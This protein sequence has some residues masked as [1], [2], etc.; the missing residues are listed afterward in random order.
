LTPAIILATPPF[1]VELTIIVCNA[2]CTSLN[3]ERRSDLPA[4]HIA[5]DSA[6][7]LAIE[8]NVH[9]TPLIVSGRI[10]CD[11][12]IYKSKIDERHG[13]RGKPFQ[14]HPQWHNDSREVCLMKDR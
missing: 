9:A 4:R 10:L 12:G 1:T 5:T 3:G 8:T 6:Q 11:G 13:E 14:D 2:T 7:L